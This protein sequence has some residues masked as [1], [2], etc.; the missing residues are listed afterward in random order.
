MLSVQI[1][2]PLSGSPHLSAS[3]SA[4]S[5]TMSPDHA[6]A[7]IRSPFESG[8]VYSLPVNWRIWPLSTALRTRS[9]AAVNAS[10]VTDVGSSP[11]SFITEP[12]VSA[13]SESSVT[14]PL[15][16]G[17]SSSCSMDVIGVEVSFSLYAM[18][19]IPDC[20]GSEYSRSG[21]N[22]GLSWAS[23]RLEKFGILS[24]SSGSSQPSPTISPG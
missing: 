17:S 11:F 12:S 6:I 10:S 7:A 4:W 8:P 13:I 19:V 23:I 24:L 9:S 15:S 20:H 1:M 18:P 21:S 22:D 16:A 3:L 14:L 2:P 5:W